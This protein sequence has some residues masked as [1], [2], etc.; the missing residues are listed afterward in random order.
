MHSSRSGVRRI[1]YTAS[2]GLSSG[3]GFSTCPLQLV[4]QQVIKTFWS[5]Q[6]T[7]GLWCDSQGCPMITYCHPRLVM[8]NCALSECHLECRRE[9]SSFLLLHGY[10]AES[11]SLSN[12]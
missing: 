4:G 3:S 2:L 8:A 12:W 5:V 6:S 1:A 10:L 9:L 11:S 7:S